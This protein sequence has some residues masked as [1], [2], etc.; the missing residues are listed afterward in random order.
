MSK[1]D[2]DGH[3]TFVAL[4]VTVCFFIIALIGWYEGFKSGQESHQSTSAKAYQNQT[5]QEIAERCAGLTGILAQKE[6]MAQAIRTARE[7]Q[8]AE[9]DL[10]AQQEMAEWTK[11]M[12]VITLIMAAI[13]LFGVYF[14]WRTVNLTR[15]TLIATQ[16]MAEDTREIGEAQVTAAKDSIAKA[17]EANRIATS[18][19]K[20]QNRPFIIAIPSMPKAAE[21][22][23][24]EGNAEWNIKIKNFGPGVAFIKSAR[25]R[26][27]TGDSDVPPGPGPGHYI[28]RISPGFAGQRENTVILPNYGTDIPILSERLC[29]GIPDDRRGEQVE[30]FT[31]EKIFAWLE[32]HIVYEGVYGDEHITHALF[33]LRHHCY[34]IEQYGGADR[35]YRS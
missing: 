30:R 16:E 12:L 28:E 25:A 34:T 19:I 3:S 21:W 33:R 13:T 11:W 6:C 29:A 26:S 2:R 5:D 10:D 24:F 27:W 32:I 7:Q 4:S 23:S 22:A 35:N 8:R 9:E 18:A 17:G 20:E 31:F 15:D 14:V 1:R